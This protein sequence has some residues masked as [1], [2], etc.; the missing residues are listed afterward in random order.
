MNEDLRLEMASDAAEF[1][2]DFGRSVIFRSLPA[3]GEAP[4]TTVETNG[5]IGDP[6]ISESLLD[7]GVR[8]VI[9]VEVKIQRS[10]TLP[11]SWRP[12][13]DIKAWIGRYASVN[14]YQGY[15]RVKEV[16]CKEGSPWVVF[17]MNHE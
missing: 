14:G 12:F 4:S 5:L 7:G 8:D 6:L 9:T 16:T 1:V 15:L 2:L 10:T 11:S 3:Q 13:T 17:M